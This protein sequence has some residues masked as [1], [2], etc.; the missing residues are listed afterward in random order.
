MKLGVLEEKAQEEM[1]PLVLCAGTGHSRD[2]DPTN[3]SRVKRQKNK[4]RINSAGHGKRSLS[5]HAKWYQG[6]NE[7]VGKNKKRKSQEQV[8]ISAAVFISD[9]QPILPL[10]SCSHS[11]LL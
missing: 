4:H 5:K 8:H 2:S 1:S 10:P 6:E 11:T 9:L 3:S 7:G